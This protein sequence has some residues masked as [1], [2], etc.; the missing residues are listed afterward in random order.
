M[1]IR[2]RLFHT[3]LVACGLTLAAASS[4]A[5]DGPP[6][7]RRE[8]LSAQ[9]RF[10]ALL[11]RIAHEQQL[12]GALR[13]DFVQIK[14]SSLLAETQTAKGTLSFR[15]PDR[16]RWEYREPNPMLIV[17][18]GETMLTWFQ[19]LGRA[20]R[21]EIGRY[22]E[23]VFRFMGATAEIDT[24]TEYFTVQS[25]FPSDPSQP[26]RLSLVPR[27]A[28]IAKKLAKM[29]IWIDPER[30]IPVR[31]EY[32]EADGDL[33]EYQLSNLDT[34]PVL[35]DELFN[36]AVPEDVELRT[37]DLGQGDRGQAR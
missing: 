19:D 18:A 27:Y 25:S 21:M 20:E 15:K 2:T 11:E 1:R 37:I 34:A 4:W 23:Q 36:L 5:A 6:D 3:T 30:F 28:R 31:L 9:Q 35:G 16:V 22:S 14:Q 26:Y 12:L 7:P 13:A 33:T 10:D 17:I 24:L 32:E 29:T 8:G